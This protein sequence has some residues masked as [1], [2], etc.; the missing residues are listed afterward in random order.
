MSKERDE[1]LAALAVTLCAF[2]KEYQLPS[3]HWSLSIFLHGADRVF[4][5]DIKSDNMVLEHIR[6]MFLLSGMSESE[7]KPPPIAILRI[8][9]F[10]EGKLSPFNEDDVE[11]E[12]D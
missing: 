7:P 3:G 2:V 10:G 5:R 6:Q 8:M 1:Q 9:G 4:D 12:L 11:I